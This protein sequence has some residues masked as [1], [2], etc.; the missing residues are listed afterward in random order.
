MPMIEVVT[1]ETVSHDQAFI[2]KKGLG[3]SI[4]TFPG[5]PESRVMVAIVDKA[6]MFFGGLEGP[7]ALISV[8]LYQAQPEATYDA[9][10]KIAVKTI[11]TA[12]PNIPLDRIYVKYQT[13]DHKAWG[14]QFADLK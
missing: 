12:L 8:A 3:E 4:V 10:A 5:K 11:R 13:L 6:Q 7:T 14:K 2:L 9:Y 1:S